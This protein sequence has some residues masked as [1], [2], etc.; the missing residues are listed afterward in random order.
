MYYL[1]N[2]KSRDVDFSL[3]SVITNHVMSDSR[4][5]DPLPD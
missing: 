2:F 3:G 4:E 5:E 1:Q